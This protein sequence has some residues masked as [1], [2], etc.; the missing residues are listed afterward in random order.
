MNNLKQNTHLL[1][2]KE[3]IGSVVS[4]GNNSAKV[5]LKITK[6]MVV[7]EY[8]LAHGSFVFGLADYAAMVTINEPTVVLGKAET[9][10]LKPVVLNDELT[11][12]ATITDKSH[13]K[14]IVVSVTVSND[15]KEI[16]F[17]GNFVCFVL[18]NHILKK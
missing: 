6:D 14:K 11:A 18:K 10:F 12:I 4:I 8:N 3:L 5:S 13:P 16:V 17:E 9:T 15:E 7:D 2:S 1:A